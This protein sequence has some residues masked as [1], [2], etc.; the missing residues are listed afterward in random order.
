MRDNVSR[1]RGRCAPPV[2]HV[3]R[4]TRNR[5]DAPDQQHHQ[6]GAEQLSS[7]ERQRHGHQ[8]H[9]DA[10]DQHDGDRGGVDEVVDGE[11]RHR[12]ARREAVPDREAPWWVRWP[13][14]PSGVRL[15]TASPARN[16]ANAR[17]NGQP[18]GGSACT[19]A[20]PRR[21]GRSAR[22]R[23]ARIGSRSPADA[24]DTVDDIG[25]A[26]AAHGVGEEH[27]ATQRRRRASQHAL[28]TAGA[29]AG[30][31]QRSVRLAALRSA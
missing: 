17:P 31:R 14:M 25:D 9:D 28:P 23:V 13:A 1:Q 18:R 19:G 5:D 12:V 21:A 30:S 24:A 20:R 2:D 7:L 8:R 16:A 15:P 29:H 3:P 26:R 6:G 10:C 11:R 22:R 27:G 4:S